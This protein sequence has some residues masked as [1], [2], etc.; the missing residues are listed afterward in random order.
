MRSGDRPGLQNRRTA[1]LPVVGGFDSHSLPPSA[2]VPS[3]RSGFRRAARTPRQRL[4]FKTGGRQVCLSSVGSTPTRF[5]QAREFLRYAQDFGARLERR[6]SASTSKPADGRFACRRWVRLPLA[7]AKRG[8]SFATLRISARG[9][10][11]AP[12]PQLQNR[13]TAGLPVVGG[14]DS[15][16]LPPSAGVPSLRSGFRRAARTPRQRLNFKTGGRQVC[17]SSVGSTPT[18]FRQA[19]EFLRYAQDFGARLERRASAST[20]KPADGRFACRRWVRLPL[21]SAKRGSSFATLR[22]SA[23]GS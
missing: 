23:R 3:L 17:L 19:R 16:S 14:F 22:I 4:N 7:S 20:S 13:R 8:S 9:S 2:G 6:A 21:A 1:G 15:H 10:N 11:A 18:R 12:A 5:R